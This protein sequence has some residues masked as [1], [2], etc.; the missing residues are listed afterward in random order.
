MTKSLTFILLS[1]HTLCCMGGNTITTAKQPTL[2]DLDKVISASKEYTKKYEQEVGMLKIKYV[3]AKSAQDKLAASRDLFT[4][5][6][7][8]KLDS[9]YAYAERKLYYAKILHNYEDSVYSELDIADI[10]IRR[11]IM[12]S[13][14]RFCLGWN[15]NRCLSICVSI[16]LV[17][18]EIFTKVFVKLPLRLISVR[19]MSGEGLCFGIR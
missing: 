13:R 1:F 17:C 9:A 19:R 4:K 16:I 10:L 6:K 2:D 15:I 12:W 3:H 8:F 14:I 18:M 7:S 11:A 5:Y